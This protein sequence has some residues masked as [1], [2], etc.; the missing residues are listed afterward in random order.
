M[1]TAALAGSSVLTLAV[2]FFA[3]RHDLRNLLLAGAGLITATGLLFPL[4]EHIAAVLLVSF[5]GTINPSGGST[6][7]IEP[8]E[9]AMLAQGVADRERTRAFARYALT[10]ALAGAAGSL[11]A[12]APD[13]SALLRHRYA[14][15]V[16]ADVCRLRACSA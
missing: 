14:D 10:G 16:P 11:A 13:F 5:F 9:H 12:A 15:R 3:P 7:A 2:G 8:L 6:S 4:S 1:A